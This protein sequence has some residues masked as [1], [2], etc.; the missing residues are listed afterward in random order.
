MKMWGHRLE[1]VVKTDPI[2][3]QVKVKFSNGSVGSIDLG[4]IFEKPKGLA[5][6]ILKG[7]IFNHCFVEAGALAWPNGFELCPDALWKW[8]KEE[9]ARDQQAA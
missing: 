3:F 5:A 4:P 9:R 2:S 6:E 8:F 1:R 7:G